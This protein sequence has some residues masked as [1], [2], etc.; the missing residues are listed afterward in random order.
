MSTHK[1]ETKARVSAVTQSLLN[2]HIMVAD[3]TSDLDAY[4]TRLERTLDEVSQYIL[5]FI[6]V[7]FYTRWLN[8]Y[9]SF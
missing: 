3:V 6:P 7:Y 4:C 1:D 9:I 5:K 2:D 8:L